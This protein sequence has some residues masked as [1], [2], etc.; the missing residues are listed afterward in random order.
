MQEQYVKWYSPNLGRDFD[1][2]IFGTNGYPLLLFPTSMG[3]YYQNKDFKLIESIEWFINTEKIQVFC[4]D[5]IDEDSWY[6]SRIHPAER[7]ANHLRYEQL[8]REEIVERIRQNSPSKRIAIGGCS[9]GGYHATNFAFRHPNLV[10][11]LFSMAGAFDIRSRVS[12]HYDDQVYYNN[13]PD[14]LPD[15]QDPYLW[16]MGIVLGTSEFDMCRDANY[17][18]S[19]IL[20]KKGVDHW[21]DDRPNA[22]HDWPVWRQMLPD[23]VSLIRY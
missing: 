2:E 22:V 11:Y 15:L 10:N 18:L 8:I 3:R 21:L 5:G 13:P 6:N 4:P 16:Q 17:Q 1:M 20:H 7:V 9:F 23:Y 19:D 14:F 12:G